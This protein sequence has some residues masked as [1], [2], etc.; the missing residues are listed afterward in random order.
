MFVLYSQKLFP[1]FT[2]ISAIKLK[3]NCSSYTP[4]KQVTMVIYKQKSKLY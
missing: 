4:Q 1:I 3:I 2:I